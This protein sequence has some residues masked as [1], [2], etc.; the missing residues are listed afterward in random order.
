MRRLAAIAAM[1]AAL[2]LPAAAQHS[3]AHGGSMGHAVS[4]PHGS[5]GSGFAGAH[6]GGFAQPNSFARYG[7]FSGNPARPPAFAP[8]RFGAVAAPR[9]F[10]PTNRPAFRPPYRGMGAGTAHFGPNHNWNGH[11]HGWDGHDHHH[12]VTY[13]HFYAGYPYLYAPYPYPI[14]TGYVDPWL[15]GPDDYDQDSSGYSA[16]PYNGT[17]PTPYPDNGAQG[18][19]PQD[20]A[21]NPYPAPDQ[22]PSQ[23]QQ[24]SG[25]RPEYAPTGQPAGSPTP[26]VNEQAVTLIFNDGR[27]SETIHNYLLTSTKLTVLDARYREIPLSQIDIAATVAANRAAG[28]DFRVP[29]ASQ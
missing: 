6:A 17:A 19:E 29:P 26:P 5:F 15:F 9:S 27:R 20:Y 7:S 11:D 25:H 28:I 21:P 16:P 24:P 3:A 4:A 23:S 12:R 13:G 18:Y 10:Y 1:V 22:T 2:I 14:F 8:Q